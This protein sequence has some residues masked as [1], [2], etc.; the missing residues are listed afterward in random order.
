ML[1]GVTRIL[2]AAHVPPRPTVKSAFLHMRDVVGYEIVAQRVAFVDGAPQ[3]TS[4]RVDGQADTIANAVGEDTHRGTVGIELQNVG[5]IFFRRS[6]IGVIDI[7]SR[8]NGNEHLLAICREHDVARPVAVSAGYVGNMFGRA[9]RLQIAVLVRKAND[10]IRVAHVNP[11]W[12]GSGRVEINS[13][14]PVQA[15]RK[16]FGAFRFSFGGD[17]V[18]DADFSAAAFGDKEIA[19][20]SGANQARLIQSR[21]VE[22]DFEARRHLR[23]GGFGPRHKFRAIA[24]GRSGKR[25][26]QIG[27]SDFAY[28]SRLF[29]PVIGEG[30]LWWR[31][32]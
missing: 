31:S 20:G 19:V 18:E 4:F 15:S 17:A 12:I 26:G 23:P 6:R 24:R 13:K 21:G 25:G 14:W 30:R 3:L 5:A 8:A 27:E 1:S 28:G 29:I 16:D 9:A 2:M 11:L 7:G 22:F 32:S 10:G